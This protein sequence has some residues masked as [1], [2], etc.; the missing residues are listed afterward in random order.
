MPGRKTKYLLAFALL[1]HVWGVAKLQQQKVVGGWRE[2]VTN[3]LNRK[4]LPYFQSMQDIEYPKCYAD[5]PSRSIGTT[6][7]SPRC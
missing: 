3:K 1:V 6:W 7:C 4:I 2:K 5:T